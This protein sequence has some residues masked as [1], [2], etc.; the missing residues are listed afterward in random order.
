[1]KILY[2]DLSMGAAGD[3]LT[4]ALMELLPDREAFLQKLAEVN[5]PGVSVTALTAE[6]CGITG[7]QM[8]VRIDGQEELPGA[9][10]DHHHGHHHGRNMADIEAVVNGLAIPGKVKKDVMAVYRLLADAESKV[11]GKP[12]SEIH[13][14]EVGAMD[15]I[16]DITA[17]CLLLEEIAPDRICA[18]PVNTGSGTV[19]CAHGVLPVPAPAAALLLQG[20][21]S[22]AGA[23]QS[24]LCTPTGAALLK[25]FVT[26]YGLQPLMR[27]QSIGYGL[28]KK[29]FEQANCLRAML[30]ETDGT[31]ETS[32]ELSFN[33]DDM[34]AE[35]LAFACE[36]LFDAGAK[37]V[38]TVP[39][40]MKKSRPG[41]LVKILCK[42]EDKAEIVRAVFRHTST[43][44]LRETA[45]HRYVL[46]RRIEELNTP[47][48]PIRVK[49]SEGYGVKKSKI[50][51]DDAARIATEHGL[52]LEEVRKLAETL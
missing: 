28:G 14:H 23:V 1:M 38:F 11:H 17:V 6:K 39:V 46:D 48:G 19:R 43:V 7:T 51:Y 18:S 49:R 13:F 50:E 52:T 37:E 36:R 33:V 41:V 9:D 10:H 16:A 22:Y 2:F 29:D 25:Y 32:V 45:Q 8:Q 5:L 21:P 47:Y 4:A 34:T 27:V 42:P 44:G 20:I 35:A 15:A 31:E 30:G 40:T 12:V 26:D 24:E 3:M